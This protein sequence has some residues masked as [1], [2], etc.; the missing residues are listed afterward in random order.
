M[1]AGSAIGG[2]GFWR[3]LPGLRRLS[4]GE[5]RGLPHLSG[6]RI[7]QWGMLVMARKLTDEEVI[8]I[9]F[10]DLP[11]GQ[12]RVIAKAYGV[13][14]ALI[15]RIRHG[16]SQHRVLHSINEAEPVAHATE[17]LI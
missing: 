3:Y 13:S 1:P 9:Y 17:E 15:C 10:M 5:D 11:H 2:S 16:K 7:E 8:G 6:L 4:D 14:A 12:Q